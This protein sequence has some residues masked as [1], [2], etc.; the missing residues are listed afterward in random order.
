MQ[1]DGSMFPALFLV[2]VA[3][4]LGLA[5]SP[6]AT[7]PSPAHFR[8]VTAGLDI[9][10]AI[11]TPGDRDSV[12][13][14]GFIVGKDGVVVVDSFATSAAAEELLAEIRRRTSAP[15]R[16]VVNTHYHLDHVGGDAVFRRAGATIL[17]H[18]NLRAWIRTEN[19]R[20][21]GEIKPEEKAMLAG[22]ALPDL[23]YRD[24]V[25]LWPGD[26]PVQVRCRPGHTGG[27]SI[28]VVGQAHVVFAGDLFWNATVPNTIDAD[29]KAWAE[30]LDGFLREFPQETFVPG[31]GQ[32]GHAL[33][34]R[35]FR[36]YVAGL[37]QT[38]GRAVENGLYGRA[39]IDAVLPLHRAR[40]GAWAWFDQ[41]AEKNI[42]FAEQEIRGTKRFAPPATP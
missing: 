29:T 21:R 30:T 5:P 7:T 9:Y 20:W 32:V 38:V 22:L 41:F 2:G 33:D 23:T 31:H 12:G 42:D 1:N 3:V 24:G 16:W 34:V 4:R 8:L 10:A 13:N 25:T 26:A 40:F 39:L 15:I 27:D 14:A 35:F 36:D 28:V 37:R 11:A 18:D 19:L 6:A 17:G